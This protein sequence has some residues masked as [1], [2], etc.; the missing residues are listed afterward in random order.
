V[1][2]G[3]CGGVSVARRLRAWWW[4]LGLDD[5]GEELRVGGVL[6]GG[7]GRAFKARGEGGWT[8]RGQSP[9]CC[10][11]GSREVQ[12]TP[13]TVQYASFIMR[14]IGSCQCQGGPTHKNLRGAWRRR[15]RFAPY[16]KGPAWCCQRFYWTRNRA[17]A[18]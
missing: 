9:P 16:A 7:G 4:Q 5:G 3:F 6:K 13:M 17:V 11:L 1:R 15:T 12:L 2:H 10:P 14:P 18:F 8:S